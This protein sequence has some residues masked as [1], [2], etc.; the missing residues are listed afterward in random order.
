MRE[1]EKRTKTSERRLYVPFANNVEDRLKL[2]LKQL[3]LNNKGLTLHVP[4][5]SRTDG[6]HS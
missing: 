4:S 6:V 5:L 2:L 1:R 3:A